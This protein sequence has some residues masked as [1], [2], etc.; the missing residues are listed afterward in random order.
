MKVLEL[1]E[2]GISDIVFRVVTDKEYDYILDNNKFKLF[3]GLSKDVEMQYGSGRYYYLSTTRSRLGGFHFSGDRSKG[4]R[5]GFMVIM[6]VLDGKRLSTIASGRPVD[7]LGRDFRKHNPFKNEMEDRLVS[8]SPYIEDASK[9]IKSIDIYVNFKYLLGD[10]KRRGN[11]THHIETIRKGVASGLPVRVFDSEEKFISGRGWMSG[12][13][14]LNE[15][16][17]SGPTD[18]QYDFDP[19]RYMS[20]SLKGL[21]GYIRGE[22]GREV[23]RFVSDIKHGVYLNDYVNSIQAD[24][25]NMNGTDVPLEVTEFAKKFRVRNIK[26]LLLAIGEKLRG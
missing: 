8:N 20:D 15:L 19:Y 7:Y 26:D 18:K 13:D 16:H 1:I 2:E 10:S 12:E 21:L 5:L 17:I 6:L 22:E 4:Q 11:V 9:F 14:A 3:S 24:L 23:E 25:H